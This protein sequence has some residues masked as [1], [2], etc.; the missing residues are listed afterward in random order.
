M[1]LDRR[2]ALRKLAAGGLGAATAPLWSQRLTELALAHADPHT[3]AAAQAAAAG[4]APWKPRVLDAHQNE[5]VVTIS[6]LIIPRT[7]TPGAEAAKVNEFIDLVLSEAQPAERR[8]FFRGLL[9][10]DARS[11]E[12]FG[13]DFVSAAPEQQTALLTIVSSPANKSTGDQLGREFFEAVKGLTI[14]GYYTS[15][16]G[17]R[18]ELKEDG[19]LFFAEYPGCRHPQHQG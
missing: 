12:L 10:M 4:A 15:E 17:L 18:Q 16:I 5:T 8:E 14:T 2:Q 1:H 19:G 7:D 6:E 13:A 3:H 9:W 11:R